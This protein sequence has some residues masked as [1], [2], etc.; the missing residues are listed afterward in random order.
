M[1]LPDC[2]TVRFSLNKQEKLIDLD[3]HCGNFYER[4]GEGYE[5]TS[6]LLDRYLCLK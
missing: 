2:D 3:Y 1:C 5:L 6:I 4:N